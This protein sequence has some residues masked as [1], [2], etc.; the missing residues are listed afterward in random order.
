MHGLMII[1]ILYVKRALSAIG[2]TRL[3][4]TYICCTQLS[5]NKIASCYAPTTCIGRK[6]AQ[7]VYSRCIY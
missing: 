3:I 6:E 7:L 1:V 4:Q 5:T 2:S